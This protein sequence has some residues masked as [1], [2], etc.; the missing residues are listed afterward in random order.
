MQR[1]LVNLV[2]QEHAHRRIFSSRLAASISRCLAACIR[3][4]D[5]MSRT[6]LTFCLCACA[7]LKLRIKTEG[8]PAHRFRSAEEHH[9]MR[10]P[11]GTPRAS[12]LEMPSTPCDCRPSSSLSSFPPLSLA[13]SCR[14]LLASL[15]LVEKVFSSVAKTS[16][17]KHGLRLPDLDS[18]RPHVLCAADLGERGESERSP[19]PSVRV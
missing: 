6:Q 10:S 19:A 4:T 8:V 9:E 18:H 7:V 2:T 17:Y 12:L 14:T 1:I 3:R 5:P 13:F 11:Y 16:P 15:P